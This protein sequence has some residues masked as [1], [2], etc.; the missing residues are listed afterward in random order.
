MAIPVINLFAGAG[1]MTEGFCPVSDVN[2]RFRIA[3]TVEKDRITCETLRLRNFCRLFPAGE[4]PEE[5]YRVLRGEISFESLWS[6]YPKKAELSA[7][8]TR[9]AELGNP[10]SCPEEA[11]DQLIEEALGGC[12]SWVLIGGPPCQAYSTAGRSRN[13]GN[14][15]YNPEQD[16]RLFLYREYVRVLGRH[17][18]AAFVF[19]NV[20]GLFSAKAEGKPLFPKIIEG[21]ASPGAFW[22][23]EGKPGF[24]HRYRLY[25]LTGAEVDE[26]GDP[27]KL[28][29]QA[30]QYG[31][32][33][34]RHR[35][36]IL[37]I[38]ED[39]D[40]SP[41]RFI[42]EGTLTGA[43]LVMKG[44][45]RLRSGLS[46]NKDSLE[47]WKGVL[48]N[49]LST[50]WLQDASNRFGEKLKIAVAEAVEQAC[51][52]SLDQGSDYIPSR[53]TSAPEWEGE[54]YHDQNLAGVLNHRSKS[55]MPTDLHRYLFVTSFAKATGRI[56]MLNDFPEEIL[57][58]HKNAK[59]EKFKDRF[60]VQ[61]AGVPAKTIT[62]HLS[63]DGHYFIHP[64]ASQCRTLTVR[65][66]ARIQT[67]P[68]N[69][70]FLGNRTEQYIQVGNAVPPLLGKMAANQ[71][72]EAIDK[73]SK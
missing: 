28:L 7:W 53:D 68:D 63:Q 30:E 43:G 21:L 42:P 4:L 18:P 67:F 38:R 46:R 47:G 71:I 20:R 14:P 72:L 69:Y 62:S 19:E 9:H 3:L 17:S 50:K 33:Q 59:T 66:A 49:A 1:G 54:W 65:E 11:L 32:P 73:T 48:Q 2:R 57:P 34:T 44:L 61:Q 23:R 22:K 55:H 13:Q 70:F 6:A 45:P 56:A 24:Q 31:I 51:E 40:G 41:K 29:I 5:Y 16:P 35:I 64:D 58:A 36:L 26:T 27:R 10:E 39:V 12:D 60:R 52:L 8:I 25:A 37:G 15:N